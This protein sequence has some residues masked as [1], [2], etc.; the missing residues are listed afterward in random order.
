MWIFVDVNIYTYT[1][2]AIWL[3]TDRNVGVVVIVIAQVRL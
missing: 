3:P 2:S 1:H